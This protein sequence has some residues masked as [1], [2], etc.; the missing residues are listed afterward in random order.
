MET[1]AAER[2]GFDL[3]FK[4]SPQP[5]RIKAEQYDDHS[6]KEDHVI[7]F[8]QPQGVLLLTIYFRA[9]DEIRIESVP[10]PEIEF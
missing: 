1:D 2:N 3:Y 10:V 7:Q 6:T 9:S 8:F 4:N 5:V